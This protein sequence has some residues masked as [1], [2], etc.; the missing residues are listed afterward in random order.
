MIATA[1]LVVYVLGY[2]MFAV[3][4]LRH[5]KKY[6]SFGDKIPLLLFGWLYDRFQAQW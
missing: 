1:G 3:T 5:L 6:R 2:W 4:T